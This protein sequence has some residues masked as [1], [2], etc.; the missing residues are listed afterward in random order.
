[1]AA[2]AV[3]ARPIHPSQKKSLV[4]WAFKPVIFRRAIDGVGKMCAWP[5]RELQILVWRS[6]PLELDQQSA[7]SISR[8]HFGF[9]IP[10]G[11]RSYN[12]SKRPK[13]KVACVS[14]HS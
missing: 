2:E 6:L 1:M 4:A 9:R 10:P 13:E 7:L 3:L 14:H 8:S 11:I 12:T 5:Q